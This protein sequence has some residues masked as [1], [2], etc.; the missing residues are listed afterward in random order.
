MREWA[1]GAGHEVSSQG[2]ISAE[3]QRS[4][5]DAQAKKVQ[6]IAAPVKTTAAK[7]T[8]ARNAAAPKAP[9]KAPVKRDGG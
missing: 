5:D 6:E 9:A 2:R 3:I 1:L 7:K 4:F 8:A